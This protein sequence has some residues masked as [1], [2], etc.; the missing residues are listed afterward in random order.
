MEV[1]T[2]KIGL[3]GLG[4]I[5]AGVFNAL[6]LNG[7]GIA[8]REGLRFEIVRALVRDEQKTRPTGVR[9]EILT[10]RFEDILNDDSIE[11][12]AEF[13]G[14][15]EP[16]GTYLAALLRA[17]KTVVTANKEAVAHRWVE[18]EQAA[19]QGSAGL[20]Y[21]ASVC[22][23]IPIIKL[24]NE[25]MQAN[26]ISEIKGIINGTT[27]Y[28]LSQMSNAGVSY[29]EALAEASAKGIAEPDPTNDVEG[30]DAA[31]K[32]S[33]LTSLAF[34]SRVPVDRVFRRGITEI[35]AE[36]IALGSELGYELKLLAIGKKR[37]REIEARVHPTFIPKDHPLAS[38][39]GSF[40]AV[41]VHGNAVGSLMLYG[42]GAGDFPTASAIISD[43]V[44]AAKATQHRYN[45]F[46]NS[47]E[48]PCDVDLT[49]DWETRF[50][51]HMEV[52]DQP[53]VLADVAGELARHGVSISSCV[54]K[55]WDMPVVPLY[56]VTHRTRELSMAAA[57][58]AL[59][60]LQSIA[61]IPGIIRVED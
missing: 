52:L 38:V 12:V 20:Y 7:D 28:I 24:I 15:V 16:A 57:I 53:G 2:V 22:G 32:L 44:T 19:R 43:L 3:L 10:T 47:A 46:N 30:H 31:C 9:P 42:R 37:G 56:I 49:T 36:D 33:I 54:Q 25:S 18:L 5:G 35:T 27:N 61:G 13:L 60:G 11:L 45:T 26:E 50:F 48:L 8:H 29:G 34:H 40:N 17:G 58:K 39:R 21:E 59:R 51:L 4:N 14:G 55:G 6:M 23:G 41:Y 1:R